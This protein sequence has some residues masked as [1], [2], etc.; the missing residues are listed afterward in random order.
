MPHT[1]PLERKTYHREYRKRYLKDPTNVE[2]VRATARRR[3]AQVRR[4][5]DS[6]KMERGCIDCG[7]RGHPAALDFDHVRG[8]KTLLVS[9]SKSIA[10]AE[11]EI[12]KCE[13]RCAN[14]H[15]IR[16]WE[17]KWGPVKPDIFEATYERAGG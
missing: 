7:Y 3:A 10:Q 8:V 1:D 2:K 16:T 5:I 11:R 4:F 14:C 17:R 9:F 15:R 12:A 6:V 13:V